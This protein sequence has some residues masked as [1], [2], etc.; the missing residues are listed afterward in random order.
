[1]RA[2]LSFK[3]P[4]EEEAFEFAKNGL[5]YYSV[6]SNLDNYLRSKLKYEELT[7]EQ[8]TA[9]Q[10]MRDKLHEFATDSGVS[11]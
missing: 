6:L 9:Y 7:E 3:L 4:D 10:N 8:S 2:S 5:S 1:M 11:V